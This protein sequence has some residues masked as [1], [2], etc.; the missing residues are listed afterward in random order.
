M[1]NKPTC[2]RLAKLLLLTSLCGLRHFNAPDASWRKCAID[3]N[4]NSSIESSIRASISGSI[5]MNAPLWAQQIRSAFAHST[6]LNQQTSSRCSPC[7]THCRPAHLAPIL[8]LS[9][10]KFPQNIE[11]AINNKICQVA[12]SR[13]P[14]QMIPQSKRNRSSRITQ[15]WLGLINHLIDAAECM[16]DSQSIILASPKSEALIC[17]LATE[18]RAAHFTNFSTINEQ[19]AS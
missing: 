4:N 7:V 10:E 14:P 5:N 16:C 8:W 11:Q 13:W 6:N 2:E 9:S 18:K 15:L 12:S 1:I 3:N 17:I 19:Q